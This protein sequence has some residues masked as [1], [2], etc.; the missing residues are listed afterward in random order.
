[1]GASD[2]FIRAPFIVEGV[3]IGVIGACI[4]LVILVFSYSSIIHFI[5]SKFG[6][7]SNWLN[8][9]DAG[10]IFK[11][12]IPVCLL[13]GIGIGFIGSFVTVRKHLDI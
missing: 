12:L 4:P 6:L 2:F 7:I 1:M 8:F 11:V 13:M 10:Q 5:N 9:L 3:V